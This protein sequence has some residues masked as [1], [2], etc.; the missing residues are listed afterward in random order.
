VGLGCSIELGS[1]IS[2]QVMAYNLTAI[3]YISSFFI[4]QFYAYTSG[5]EIT[6]PFYTSFY[7][8]ND[9]SSA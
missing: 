3:I 5:V 1:T 6:G 9:I 2:D 7:L 8:D 4:S